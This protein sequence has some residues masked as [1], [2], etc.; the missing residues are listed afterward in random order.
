MYVFGMDRICDEGEPSTS[1]ASS[2]DNSSEHIATL[3]HQVHTL[4]KRVSELEQ[5]HSPP[6]EH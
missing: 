5:Y 1:V 3:Q 4:Q 2:A 6:L